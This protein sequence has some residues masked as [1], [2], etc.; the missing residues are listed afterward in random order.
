MRFSRSLAIS[1]LITA[2]CDVFPLS[3]G[4]Q[5]SEQLPSLDVEARPYGEELV[6]PYRQP[7]WSARGRFSADTDVYVQPPFSFY[8]DLDYRGTLPR[9][10]KPDHLFVQEFELGLPCRFQLAFELDEESQNGQRQIPFST[11]EGRYALADWG[12]IPL[13]PT[14]FAEYSWGIGKAYPVQPGENRERE[15]EGKAEEHEEGN[16]V[17]DTV[18]E[19]TK[20]V[21][22]SWEARLLLGQEIAKNIE[23]AANL[24]YDQET[25][26]DREREMGFSTATS[27]AL[28][29]EALKVGLE[30]SYRNVSQHGERSKA[31][32]I[33]EIGPSFTFKP[34]PR[35]RF[36]I[37]PL[38]G[39]TS[40][41]PRLEIFTIFSVDFGTGAANEIEEPKVRGGRL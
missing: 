29:G 7:R 30:T 41:S 23:F 40:D 39:A 11:I 28:R 2:C 31:K 3:V 36:D 10:G 22:D 21:P 37:A 6:G 25:G 5:Q 34:S 24:F 13:N 9:Q 15:D 27:Y 32:N 14:L 1:L 18:R 26:A 8:L 12:K 16:D 17:A 4:A 38:V 33:F 20:N 35:T 19:K